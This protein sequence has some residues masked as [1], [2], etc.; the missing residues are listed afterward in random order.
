M[1]TMIY[2]QKT[3]RQ[4]LSEWGAVREPPR[5]GFPNMLAGYMRVSTR[6]TVRC[7]TFSVTRSCPPVSTSVT[8]LRIEPVAAKANDVKS[9]C[10]PTIW[11]PTRV[12]LS[13]SLLRCPTETKDCTQYTRNPENVG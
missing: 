13:I 10:N 7:W 4:T 8:R 2:R 5:W 9:G 3:A 6:A 1:K 12:V 11:L